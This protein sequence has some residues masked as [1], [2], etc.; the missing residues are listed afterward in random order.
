MLELENI[1]VVNIKVKHMIMG[2]DSEYIK[3]I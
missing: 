3:I 1:K 2:Q